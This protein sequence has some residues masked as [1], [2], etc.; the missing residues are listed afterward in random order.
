MPNWVS[1]DGND[2]DVDGANVDDNASSSG[3]AVTFKKCFFIA[4][5]YSPFLTEIWAA[6]R[7][8]VSHLWLQNF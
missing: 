8:K 2:D 3:K 4:V 5:Q 6:Q 1:G 7:S